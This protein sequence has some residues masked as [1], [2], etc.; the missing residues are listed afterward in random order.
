MDLTSIGTNIRK[1]RRAKNLT[2]DQLAKM[3]DLT[4]TYIGLIERGRKIPSLEVF[5]TI[6]NALEISSDKVLANVLNTGYI[7]RSSVLS[8]RL[9][10]VSSSDREYI[11]DILTTLISH[12]TKN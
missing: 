8:H 10:A 6:L 7:L 4:P 1:Y 11:N 3:T 5:V 12:C 2:Q 9:M